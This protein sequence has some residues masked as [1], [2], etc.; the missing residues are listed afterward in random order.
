MK[1]PGSTLPVVLAILAYVA[2]DC[3]TVPASDAGSRGPAGASA[4][5]VNWD[6]VPAILA[7]IK[8]PQFPARDFRIT[9]FGAK[10]DGT[11]D[12]SGAIAQ[13]IAACSSAGGGRVLVEGGVFLTG[14]VHLKSNVNLHVAAGATLKFSPDPEKFLPLVRARFEGT[15]VMNYSPLIYAFQQENIAVT[16]KGTLDGSASNDTWWALGRRRGPEIKGSAQLIEMGEK[17]VPVEQRRFGPA[18]SLRPNFIVPY[19]CKNILIEDVRI[20]NSPMWEINPVLCTNVTVRGVDISSHGPNNDGCDP[21]SCR[22]VLIENCL[23][24]TGDDCIAIKSGKDADGRRVG[25]PSEN[26]VIRNCVMKDG[27]GGVVL[28]SENSGGIRNVFAENCRMDSPNLQRALRLKTN[29]GR[30]GFLENVYF[31]NVEVGRVS[32]SILTI[33]LVYQRVT[34]GAFVPTVRNVLMENVTAKSA[35]R[36]LSVVGIPKSVIE[37]VRIANSR[38]SGVEG[39]D[40]LAYSGD[41]AYHNVTIEPVRNRPAAAPASA[42]APRP[43]SPPA[44][45]TKQ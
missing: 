37:N 14:A 44:A 1:K 6:S 18:G 31:R 33:D 21:D 40:I 43:T 7:R 26:L 3:A 5:A 10:G 24:D 34:E 35:P 42:P 36:V 17:G 23:F 32:D 38:F 29:A 9:D 45:G 28:G 4:P 2:G 16:G 19:L 15:E 13:A 22:D 27:H 30:G 39:A 25:V 11:T 8:A 41:I 12:C 20:V